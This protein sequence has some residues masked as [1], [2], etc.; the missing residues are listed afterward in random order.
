MFWRAMILMPALGV[1][2][3]LANGGQQSS[4]V[5]PISG[6]KQ[7][8]A[9]AA[10]GQLTILQRDG[11]SGQLCPLA[12]TSVQANVAGFGARV[13]VTQVFHNPTQE[14]IEALY[15]FPLPENAAVDHMRMK[16][17]DR[18]V[19]GLI[20]P[21]EEARRIY[22][23]AKSQGQAA[24]LLDQERSNIF[25]QSV[26][27]ILP[28]AEVDIEIDYVQTLKFESGTFEFNFPMVVGPRFLGNAK[29]LD[30]IAPP[31]TPKGTRTGSNIDLTVNLDAGAPVQELHSVLHEIDTK[32]IDSGHYKIALAHA[33]E[34]P[35]RDFILKY[36][37][38]SDT[39]TNAFVTHMDPDKG[40]FFALALLPP[41][42]ITQQDITPREFIFVMDQSGSQS[43]FPIAKS[44]ELTLKLI[45]TLRLMDTFNVIGFNNSVQKLWPEPRS[46][47]PENLAAANA[48]VSQMDAN[49]GTQLRE[50]LIASLENQQ[51]PRR[52]RMIVFSTDG[53]VGDENLI[54]DT[55][56][57]T[58]QNAR[59]FT[60][61]I[62]NSVNRYLIDSMSA[63]GRGAAEYV[64]LADDAAAATQRFIQRTR[65]PVLT[66]VSVKVQGAGVTDVEPAIVKDVFD[67]SPVYVFGRYQTPGKAK[68]TVTGNHGGVPWSKTIDVVLPMSN[69]HPQIMSLWARDRVDSL[70]RENY[71]GQFNKEGKDLK[72]AITD[73]ALDFGIMTEYTSFVAVESRVVN[74]GGKQR[75]VH[76]PVE[77]ADGVSY[78][79]IFG[80]DGSA[81]VARN[82]QYQLRMVH[83]SLGGGGGAQGGATIV[84]SNNVMRRIK[85]RSADPAFILSQMEPEN[86]IDKK[87]RNAK[88]KVEIQIWLTSIDATVLKTL[89][90]KGA[91]VELKDDKLKIV[92]ATCDAAKLIE[93]AAMAEV[94]RIEPLTE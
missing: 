12:H 61:G 93:I 45:G 8:P 3:F 18:V 41:K 50:G 60:F 9:D 54:L 87:L 36:Q 69:N 16:I 37:V 91:H 64:T 89:T 79:G 62:G 49:G 78:D 24:S 85:I 27:N 20:K 40:G 2:A 44:K 35:N 81:G 65:T 67:Q 42:A 23:A 6:A 90:E 32:K 75:L 72:S 59:V 48:F 33:D 76:V 70:T 52:L 58:R 39:V 94:Q 10:P 84:P 22:E 4:R 83:G 25:T 43:G 46:N 11:T 56:Q 15:T 57:K 30:K 71:A 80:K 26:A 7:S 73:T 5:A 51:D 66:D 31:I 13:S 29:D 21:R 88:G 47:T 17:G 14:P 74:I 63:E 92:F 86:K 55:L 19:E 53:Y 1:L 82:A 68:I 28:G 34:I 38:S 77:M